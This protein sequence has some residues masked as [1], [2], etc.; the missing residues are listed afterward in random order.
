M[1]QQR[2][3]QDRPAFPEEAVQWLLGATARTV[4]VLGDPLIAAAFADYGHDVTDVEG[5]GDTLPFPDRSVDVVVSTVRVPAD[6]PS[7]ARVLRP[8]GQFGLI[9]N[10]RDQR[11]P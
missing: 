2:A 4:V 9:C 5:S 11:I 6:L 10:E 3:P 1:D 7:I 8:G